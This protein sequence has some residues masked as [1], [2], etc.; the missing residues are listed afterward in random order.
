ME[1]YFMHWVPIGELAKDTE[2]IFKG[3]G[4]KASFVVKCKKKME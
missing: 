4:L 1:H 2:I 3:K